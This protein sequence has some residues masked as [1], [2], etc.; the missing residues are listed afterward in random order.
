MQKKNSSTRKMLASGRVNSSLPSV[1]VAPSSSHQENTSAMSLSSLPL[2]DRQHQA[3]QQ[4][5][6]AQLAEGAKE[7]KERQMR[8][9]TAEMDDLR[10]K[11]VFDTFLVLLLPYIFH[12]SSSF[13][14]FFFSAVD[15]NFIFPRSVSL[16]ASTPAGYF[17]LPLRVNHG[18]LCCLFVRTRSGV[19]FLPFRFTDRLPTILFLTYI[20]SSS[21]YI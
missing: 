20:P 11:W 15:F 21:L 1:I 16:S 13:F 12:L 6:A 5:L 4:Q 3:G 8:R 9:L 14:S 7:R 17:I 18:N 2:R 19:S 10:A